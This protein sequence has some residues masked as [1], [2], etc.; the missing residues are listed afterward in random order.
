MIGALLFSMFHV[1]FDSG[2][3]KI[4]AWLLM[5]IGIIL[6]TGKAL[7]PILFEEIPKMKKNFPKKKRT[8]KM[9]TKEVKP[10]RA[11]KRTKEKQVEEVAVTIEEPPQQQMTDT[12]V[13]EEE[14]KEPIISAFTQNIKNNEKQS[15]KDEAV[16]AKSDIEQVI[17]QSVESNIENQNYKLPSMNLLEV[18]QAHD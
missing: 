6:I 14:E 4:A 7:I 10:K 9:V 17:Q 5:L 16:T 15:E 12:F 1:L 13:V 8:K 18:P 11:V 2:G 3:A